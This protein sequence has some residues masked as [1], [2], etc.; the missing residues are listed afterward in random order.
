[1]VYIT[2]KTADKD[3]SNQW[4]VDNCDP[5]GANT[6]IENFVGNCV[7]SLA[8]DGSD[9]TEKMKEHFGFTEHLNGTL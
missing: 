9:Y 4:V 1:M 8:D 6:F 5:N 7:I 2:V 3:T